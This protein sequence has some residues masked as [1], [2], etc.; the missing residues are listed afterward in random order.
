MQ[1]VVTFRHSE[2]NEAVRNHAKEKLLKLKKYLERP[3]EA[4]VVL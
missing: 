4:R 2:A 3:V 1:V